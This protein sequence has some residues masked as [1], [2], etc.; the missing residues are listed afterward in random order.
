MS[1]DPG[2]IK[3]KSV[4][5]SHSTKPESEDA[6]STP[7]WILPVGALIVGILVYALFAVVPTFVST[8]EAVP[9]AAPATESAAPDRQSEEDELPPFQSLQRE[10]ARKEAQ[11]ELGRFVELDLT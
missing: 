9:I 5:L 4:R 8:P 1:E 10:Q 6:R 11:D 2:I 3:P 7:R